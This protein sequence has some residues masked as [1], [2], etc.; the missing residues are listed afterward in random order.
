[1]P[2]EL[3]ESNVE[4]RGA[5]YEIKH[6]PVIDAHEI[7]RTVNSTPLDIVGIY[8]KVER[9]NLVKKS[10]ARMPVAVRWIRIGDL[11]QPPAEDLFESLVESAKRKAAIV[12]SP[13]AFIRNAH[14]VGIITTWKKDTVPMPVFLLDKNVS[15]E[16]KIKACVTLYRKIA[17]LHAAGFTHLHL[18]PDNA[19]VDS[20]DQGHMVDFTQMKRLTEFRRW[21][22]LIKFRARLG[23]YVHG[24][25]RKAIDSK[26]RAAYELEYEKR[27]MIV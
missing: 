6:L 1:M 15:S 5:N 27:R 23:K 19:L 18:N 24:D 7:I 25:L 8:P 2:L 17:R 14:K 26:L 21:V 10:G 22:D 13:I 12:E 16:R 20:K 9:F 4:Y 3:I 11:N